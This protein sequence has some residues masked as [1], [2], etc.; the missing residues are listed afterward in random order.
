MA[1]FCNKWYLMCNF[2]KTKFM[3]FQNGGKL[4]SRECWY[5]NRQKLK[6]VNEIAYLG[7]KLEKMG[8][9]KR[10]KENV[11]A[12]VIPTLKQSDKCLIMTPNMG[13][14]MTGSIYEIIC[15]SRIICN[16]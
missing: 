7:V 5:M 2:D 1:D 13:K 15:E 9:W 6:E 8:E 14:K 11:K 10:Q 16:G 3:I 4:K 12:K